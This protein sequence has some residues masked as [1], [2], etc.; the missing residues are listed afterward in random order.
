M[1]VIRCTTPDPYAFCHQPVCDHGT[2]AMDADT[3]MG[4]GIG[5]P[6]FVFAS[7]LQDLEVL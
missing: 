6:I 3:G 4:C 1:V 5:Y 2:E 7:L